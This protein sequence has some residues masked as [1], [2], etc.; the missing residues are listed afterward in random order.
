MMAGYRGRPIV[1]LSLSDDERCFLEQQAGRHRAKEFLA[2]LKEIDT[3]VADDL[4]IHIIMDNYATH[5]TKQVKAWLARRPHYHVH[6]TPTSASWINHVERWFA[7]LARK[8][9]KRGV[10]TSVKQLEADI[11]CFM[12]VHNGNPKPFKWTKSADEIL[13]SVKRF[14]HRVDKNLCAEHWIQ[15]NSA[16]RLMIYSPRLTRALVIAILAAC[17][18]IIMI[19]A[20]GGHV[21]GDSFVYLKVATNIFLNGCVSLSDPAIGLCQPHWGGNQLPG[22]PAFIALIWTVFGK[23]ANAVLFAQTVVFY[24]AVARL[25]RVLAEWKDGL[26]ED[27]YLIWTLA[28]LLGASPSLVGWS[29]AILTETLS[30]A[31]ALWLLAELISSLQC[32]RLRVF[33]IGIVVTLGVF[34]RYDFIMFAVPVAAFGFY[35]HSP[36]VAIRKGSL[37]ALIILVP[38]G[39]WTARC[40][41]QG[42]DYTPPFGLTP[43]GQPLPS[44][45]LDWTGTWLDNQ[46]DLGASVWTLVHFDYVSF[47]PPHRAF[48][49]QRE[50]LEVRTLL[51]Q[52]RTSYQDK[53]PPKEIDN[54]FARIAAAKISSDPIRHWILLPLSRVF[55]MWLTPYPGMGWPAEISGSLRAELRSAMATGNL[56][57]VAEAVLEMPGTVAM[58]VLVSGHRYLLLIL[59]L[60]TM[61]FWRRVP[62][63]I[64]F[65]ALTIIGFAI[66]RSVAFSYTILSETR[67]L[68]PALAWLDV[69]LVV[70]IFTLVKNRKTREKAARQE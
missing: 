39:S 14:C 5:R 53:S 48:D 20:G 57:K 24:A 1:V 18:P 45:M 54:Q 50:E 30:I 47:T 40:V 28:L 21:G 51:E 17:G 52:L 70:T 16:N 23:S 46:Y 66:L 67:Y 34:V 32:S 25:C 27:G 22:Y 55:H 11:I 69:L 49:S 61:L 41:S 43:E 12:D 64:S 58:K 36:M 26:F 42:L 8:Q 62:V 9:I 19:L 38:L 4:D 63:E 44:G 6:F 60:A 3:R 37:I 15:M 29:R 7:E 2:F 13:A 35:L 65:L 59:V 10:F 31:L 56:T 33:W 68:T